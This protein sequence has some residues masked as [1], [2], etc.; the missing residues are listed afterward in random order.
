MGCSSVEE[1]KNKTKK[2]QYPYMLPPCGVSTVHRTQTNFVRVGDLPNVITDAKF[3][4]N[5]YKIVRLAKGWSFMF[6]H[7]YGGRH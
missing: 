7:Y 3:D 4:I 2:S 1:Y 5:W 6:Q